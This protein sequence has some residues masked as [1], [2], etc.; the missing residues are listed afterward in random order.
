MPSW[1]AAFPPSTATRSPRELSPPSSRRPVR[2]RARTAVNSSGEAAATPSLN[3]LRRCGSTSGVA[4]TSASPTSSSLRLPAATT[5]LS[6]PR[7][8]GASHGISRGGP[9]SCGLTVIMICVEASSSNRP[10][11]RLPAV[12]DSPSVATRAPR[13]ITVPSTVS[14][15][16]PGRASR[17]ATA[18]SRRSRAPTRA[19]SGRRAPTDPANH[20]SRTLG[21]AGAGRSVAAELPGFR[22]SAGARSGATCASPFVLGRALS[23]TDLDPLDL[24]AASRCVDG[25]RCVDE[26][27]A[28]SLMPCPAARRRRCEP[29]ALPA[30]RRPGRE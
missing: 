18:S 30:L 5:P 26:S 25:S 21:D 4:V 28:S 19:G 27:L 20:S 2:R 10:T 24:L 29:G 14:S 12:S 6:R 16:R 3:S 1:A 22:P 23:S 7:R 11:M 13:P 9:V 17:P 8:A 15:V